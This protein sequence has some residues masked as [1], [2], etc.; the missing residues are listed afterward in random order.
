MNKDISG[1]K[2]IMTS[3]LQASFCYDVLPSKS[4]STNEAGGSCNTEMLHAMLQ[5]MICSVLKNIRS[6]G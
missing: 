1:Q 4:R 3:P 2:N 6:V 5:S